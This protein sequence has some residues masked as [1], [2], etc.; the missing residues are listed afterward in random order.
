MR[1]YCIELV[2]YFEKKTFVIHTEA[3]LFQRGEYSSWGGMRSL[4]FS[5]QSFNT[6]YFIYYKYDV[7]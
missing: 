2:L 5:M 7:N 6:D 1:V 4:N 3:K